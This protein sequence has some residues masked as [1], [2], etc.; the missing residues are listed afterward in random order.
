LSLGWFDVSVNSFGLLI[1]PKLSRKDT[2]FIENMR[3]CIMEVSSENR[4]CRCDT[5]MPVIGSLLKHEIYQNESQRNRRKNP[6]KNDTR[7]RSLTRL[8]LDEVSAFGRL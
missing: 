3:V 5:P 1:E 7:M 8:G 6:Q 4:R 2:L